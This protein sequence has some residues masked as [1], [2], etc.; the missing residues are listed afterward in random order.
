MSKFIPDI[1]ILSK[2]EFVPSTIVVKG[3]LSSKIDIIVLSKFLKI[4]HKF[5]K[6]NERIRLVSGT[7]KGIEYFG[8]E[9]CIVFVGYRETKRGMRTGA[10]NNMV[11]I[12]LQYGGK[13]IHIKLS[14]SSITSVGTNSLEAGKKA[15]NKIMEHINETK[16][17][18]EFSNSLE[19]TEKN[20]CIEWLLKYLKDFKEGTREEDIIKV[21]DIPEKLNKKFIYNIL[22]YYNDHEILGDFYDHISLLTNKLSLSEEEISCKEYDIYNSVYHIRPID[23][24]N[25]I[26]P[27]NKLAP[28][29]ANEGVCTTWHN[30]LSEGCKICFDIEN[31]KEGVNHED[32]Y[33]KHRITILN[34]SKII[35]SSPTL[36]DEAYKYY[37]GTIKLIQ[38]FLNSQDIDFKQYVIKDFN[39][40]D[41]L[42]KL[43]KIKN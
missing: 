12:D 10:M 5:N 39:K 30:A 6:D 1:K 18:L 2:K 42:S 17:F 37:L 23:N 11:S 31:I 24:P 3:I 22:K 7:R 29:L 14:K 8:P 26:L 19:T 38:K 15:V 21:I 16:N 25:F 35:Q 36:R 32:K 28:F 41:T 4:T 13:N 27:L 43:N 9:G 40:I 33:Y 20:N 34:T